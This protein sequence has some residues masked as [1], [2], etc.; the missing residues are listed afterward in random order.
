MNKTG[1]IYRYIASAGHGNI[2]LAER[3][4]IAKGLGISLSQLYRRVQ[5]YKS[6][7]D[8][9]QEGWQEKPRRKNSKPID[10]SGFDI[11]QECWKKKESLV[12]IKPSFMLSRSKLSPLIESFST[13]VL[14]DKTLS[15]IFEISATALKSARA[16]NT[17]PYKRYPSIKA[18]NN[19]ILRFAKHALLRTEIEKKFPGIFLKQ[20]RPSFENEIESLAECFDLSRA[21]LLR[22]IGSTKTI[23]EEIRKVPPRTYTILFWRESTVWVDN[24]CMKIPNS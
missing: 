24:A 2:A 18:R 22:I 23:K 13:E 9:W 17:L 4:E 7:R 3:N 16:F 10:L 15:Q 8:D 20:T 21:Q 5:L 12:Y 11:L 6:I 19:E 1:N 14:P